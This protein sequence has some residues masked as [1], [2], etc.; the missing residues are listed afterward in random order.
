ME[1]AAWSSGVK[2]RGAASLDTGWSMTCS[3]WAKAE[4]MPTSLR[5][6]PHRGGLL[7]QVVPQGGWGRQGAGEPWDSERSVGGGAET[8]R[9]CL[10]GTVL[11]GGSGESQCSRCK[12]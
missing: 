1:R 10:G 6:P 3:R 2:A 8:G 9:S 7:R 5:H 11:C 4:S 12:A